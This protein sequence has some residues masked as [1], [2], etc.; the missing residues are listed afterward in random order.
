MDSQAGLTGL[1]LFGLLVC[2]TL[3]GSGWLS[4]ARAQGPC[5]NGNLNPGE[6]CDEGS[7]VNGTLES[8]CAIDCTFRTSGSACSLGT[9]DLCDAPN[10]CDGAGTCAVNVASSTTICRAAADLCDVP[11]FCD[12]V[13]TACGADQV[14]TAGAPC[15]PAAGL[16][17]VPEACDGASI[18][19]PTDAVS[20]STV[21]CRGAAGVC[22]VPESCDGANVDCPA[23]A[24]ASSSV[25][26]RAAAGICDVAES[27]DGSS[28][29]CPT[30]AVAS[31]TVVCRGAAGTCDVPESCD[32]SSVDCP[33]DAV[34]PSTVVCRDA[35]GT[36]DVPES[37]DGS[38]VDCPADAVS[39][40]N[41]VC[42][43][44]AGACD[45]AESCDG[46][47]VDCPTDAVADSNVVCRGA[48][49]VCDVAE[50][51]DGSS[52]NCPV[53]AKSTAVCRP[54]TD[55]AC[56]PAESCD[57]QGNDCPVD[58]YTT[59]GTGCDDG[60][61]CTIEDACSVGACVGNPQTCG[62][63]VLQASCGEE[64]DDGGTSPDDGCS[65]VCTFETCRAA[66]RSDCFELG[67]AKFIA[68]EPKPTTGNLRVILGRTETPVAIEDFGDFVNGSDTFSLCVYDDADSLLRS[69]V[70]DRGGDFC[71]GRPCWA[72]NSKT[73]YSFKDLTADDS[74]I[75][76]MR[77]RPGGAPGQPGTS[78][79]ISGKTVK[80]PATSTLPL[81]TADL[82][83]NSQPTIQTT[84]D[85]GLCLSAKLD[86]GVLKRPGIYIGRKR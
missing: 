5:G 86:V 67:S 30:D 83:G 31:S 51:C 14:A 54:S 26:C 69:Y 21:V 77:L 74:G 16:C 85:T 42:R 23:D 27:C 52:P 29:N 79:Q 41:V 46:S 66:P 68:K 13:S 63:N 34:S 40:S 48:A 73:G 20:P 32:G 64:C 78:L 19:C 49:G 10:T 17:D 55:A 47:S 38:S 3:A 50:S 65:E 2:A 80:A 7:G 60:N 8:C 15:R 37:C 62:D 35:A 18:E 44:A 28:V 72:V 57:G 70:V 11:E 9:D 82:E 75:F 76:K 45:V 53:D 6:Q 25:V 43:G 59:N 33:T 12:G 81:I 36:C 1:S 22:D 58:Q 56:D 84:F 61:E 39:P 71:Q 24:V 4:D